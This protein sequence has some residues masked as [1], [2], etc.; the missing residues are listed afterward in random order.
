MTDFCGID[1]RKYMLSSCGLR[2]MAKARNEEAA[3]EGGSP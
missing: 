3:P 2:P 1:L